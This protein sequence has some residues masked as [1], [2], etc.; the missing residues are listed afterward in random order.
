MTDDWIIEKAKEAEN[1]TKFGYLIHSP[2]S[3]GVN[4]PYGVG[5]IEGMVKY[6]ESLWHDSDKKQPLVPSAI[7]VWDP[8]AMSGELMTSCS[9]VMPGRLWAYISDLLPNKE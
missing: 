8:K 7:V 9:K 4:S 2:K 3:R 5:F 6:R 1:E